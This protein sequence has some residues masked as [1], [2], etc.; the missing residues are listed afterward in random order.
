MPPPSVVPT[1]WGTPCLATWSSLNVPVLHS[2]HYRFRVELWPTGPEVVLD[3]VLFR[4]NSIS[5]LPWGLA[6]STCNLV[7]IGTAVPELWG[8]MTFK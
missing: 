4:P 3:I 2:W 8:L 5:L 1:P 6:L 7:M